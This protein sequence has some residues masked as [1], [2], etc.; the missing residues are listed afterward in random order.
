MLVRVVRCNLNITKWFFLTIGSF[1]NPTSPTSTLATV[2]TVPSVTLHTIGAVFFRCN[3]NNNCYRVAAVDSIVY[4]R[5]DFYRASGHY[6][7]I[8]NYR[9]MDYYQA[10]ERIIRL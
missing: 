9:A 7:R 6:R 10:L 8:D 5:M 1:P 4:R 2:S 3:N